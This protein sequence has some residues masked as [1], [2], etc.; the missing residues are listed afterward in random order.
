MKS[1]VAAV[2]DAVPVRGVKG[3]ANENIKVTTYQTNQ[4]SHSRRDGVC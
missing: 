1:T 2:V 4:R 3:T